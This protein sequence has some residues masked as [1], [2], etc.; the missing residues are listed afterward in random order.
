VPGGICVIAVP[1]YFIAGAQQATPVA[2]IGEHD[3]IAVVVVVASHFIGA[4]MNAAFA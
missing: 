1:S 3:A 4:R 2:K